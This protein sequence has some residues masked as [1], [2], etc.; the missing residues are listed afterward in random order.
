MRALV[1]HR[2]WGQGQYDGHGVY[3]GLSTT[4]EDFP[5]FT[6]QTYS[7]LCKYYALFCICWQEGSIARGIFPLT[8]NTPLMSLPVG[9]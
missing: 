5:I 2:P 9:R 8:S 6:T 7:S 1:L 3:W 4:S